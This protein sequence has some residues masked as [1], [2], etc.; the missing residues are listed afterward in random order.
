MHEGPQGGGPA[1]WKGAVADACCLLQAGLRIAGPI[2]MVWAIAHLLDLSGCRSR[3]LQSR[4]VRCGPV[5]SAGR[6]G[7]RLAGRA[8]RRSR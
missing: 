6:L 4:V 5:S 8:L 2:L 7:C 1:A 3:V